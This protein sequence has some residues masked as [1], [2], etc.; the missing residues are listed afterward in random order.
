MPAL[1]VVGAQWGDEGKGKVVHYLGRGADVVAR[2]QGGNNAGHTVIF[3][4]KTFALHL[5]PSGILI[6]GVRTIIG[7][8]VV[9]DPEALREEILFLESRGVKVRGRLT[10]SL[11][12][13][14]ILP[15]HLHRDVLRESGTASIG[16]TQRGIGPCYEDKVARV[17]IRVAD[18]LEP[19]LFEELLD[20]NLRVREEELKRAGGIKKLKADIL[21]RAAKMRP[22]LKPY[23][24]DAALELDE[25]L[26]K[27]K[28]A[29]L[30]GAQGVMLDL[31]VGTYPYVTS[32][33]PIAGGAC[34][35]LGLGPSAVTDV[36]GVVKAYTTRVGRGPFPTEIEGPVAHY[37]RE[38][39]REYGATTGRP[40]RIGW[41]DFVQLRHAIR[42]SGIRRIALT[43]LD[44]L[45]HIHPIKVCVAYKIGGKP[46][47]HFPISRTALWEAEPVYEE[48][49][50][51]AQDL[52][53]IRRHA[54][55]PRSA[56][57]YL[58]RIEDELGI[59]VTILSLG[60]SREKTILLD[61]KF[62]W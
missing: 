43:K 55:L 54:D 23:C 29:L 21:K 44:T 56:K 13:H 17:G 35:G 58:R 41:L 47:K 34:V 51:I 50:G 32:S 8:G 59:P 49:E 31:D 16:T 7:H 3:D 39:G 62:P 38:K 30:E 10:V 20:L 18:Y 14:V 40:R 28:R 24:G 9:V 5:L 11:G 48:L 12:A 25:S 15:Y 36:M 52:T 4:G 33:S 42:A 19:D 1:V 6:P 37:L 27:G 22:W 57:D 61:K 2:Y 53:D 26:K 60:P 45:S 46:T